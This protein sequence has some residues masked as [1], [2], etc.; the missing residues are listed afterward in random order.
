MRQGLTYLDINKLTDQIVVT[1]KIDPAH[2]FGSSGQLLRILARMPFNEHTLYR[3]D[4]AF[5]DGHGLRLD[6]CLQLSQPGQLF[7]LQHRIGQRRCRCW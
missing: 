5:A 7:F 6:S 4:H 3:T 2:V 1:V